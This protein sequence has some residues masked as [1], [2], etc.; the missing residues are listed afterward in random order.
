MLKYIILQLAMST[1]PQRLHEIMDLVTSF[2]FYLAIQPSQWISNLV[3]VMSPK[4]CSILHSPLYFHLHS[5][6]L[7]HNNS[8]LVKSYLLFPSLVPF[9]FL[10]CISGL[11]KIYQWSSALVWKF[12]T[13]GRLYDI[14]KDM[15]VTF[16]QVLNPWMGKKYKLTNTSLS[17]LW[18]LI[19]S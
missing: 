8:F 1:F 6:N 5:F 10:M 15:F 17:I 19:I 7:I 13:C 14:I 18:V 2:S 11:F 9:V 4:H 3:V 12:R 16:S